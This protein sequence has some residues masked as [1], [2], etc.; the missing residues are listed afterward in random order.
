MSNA[1]YI[2]VVDDDGLFTQFMKDVLEKGFDREVVTA[3]SLQEALQRVQSRIPA[4]IFFDLNLPDGDGEQFCREIS[5]I[6]EKKTVPK[7]I[8]SGV[9]P[10]FGDLKKWVEYGVEGYL[11]KPV[12]IDTIFNAVRKS[13]PDAGERR[14]S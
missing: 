7:W 12:P 14:S 11:V 4:L 13:L 6:T 2:L 8:L 5:K 10:L 1:G 3:D 9:S